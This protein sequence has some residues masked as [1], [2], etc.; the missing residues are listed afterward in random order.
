MAAVHEGWIEELLRDIPADDK[1]TM[2]ALLTQMKGH[3]DRVEEGGTDEGH[4]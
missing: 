4:G 1:G 3:L 2:I